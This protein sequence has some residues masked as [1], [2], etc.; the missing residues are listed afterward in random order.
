MAGAV[1]ASSISGSLDAKNLV[2]DVLTRQ[3]ELSN[4]A[5]LALP[6]PVPELEATVP[7]YIPGKADMDLGEW[8]TTGINGGVF[9]SV[10]FSLK[11]D[12]VKLGVSTEAKYK[13]KKGDPLA[14]QKATNAEVL[15]E[16]LDYRIAKALEVNPQ[17]GAAGAK[18]S[19]VTNNPLIDLAKAVRHVKR[20][21]Y[22]IMHGDVWT[23][24]V[25]NDYTSKYVV[26]NPEKL[27]GVMTTIP[28]LE[29]KVYVS[30][31]ITAKSCIIGRSSAPSVAIGN[32]PVEVAEEQIDTSGRVYQ[33]D[34][35]RQAV[36]PIIPTDDG[37]NKGAYQLTGVIA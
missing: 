24:F 31:D 20:A 36:A 11:K 37:K 1:L 14:I 8:E 2:L 25:G 17:T 15:A 35:F 22:V 29:L 32:G 26:G 19:T 21:D 13:S 18:W 30:D 12:R 34:V 4:L 27:K 16:A 23:A 5:E 28:G 7:I 3:I 10:K 33:I 6:V 9:K